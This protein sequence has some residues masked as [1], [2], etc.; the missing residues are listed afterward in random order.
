MNGMTDVYK[1]IART[2]LMIKV[3]H[4]FGIGVM[5]MVTL[6]FPKIATAVGV[7][8][9]SVILIYIAVTVGVTNI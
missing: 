9:A 1:K 8:L 3:I 4:Y 6:L 5:L 7:P 2:R